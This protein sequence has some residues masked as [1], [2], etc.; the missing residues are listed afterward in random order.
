MI[1]LG[2]IPLSSLIYFNWKIYKGIK[3]PPT[4]L[5]QD[6]D[7]KRRREQDYDLAKVLIGIVVTFISCHTFRVVI[8]FH[9]IMVH[10]EAFECAKAGL[11]VFSMWSILI[12]YLSD[13]M[14]GLNS[15]V[16]MIIYCCLNSTF[17]K[18]FFPCKNQN[19]NRMP[20]TAFT[21][22]IDISEDNIEMQ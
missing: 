4:L 15:S 8:E 7:R 19:L 6:D 17:R 16:N 21:R 20:S 18:S 1:I 22:T 11:R 5:Q 2:I 9:N 10:G 12:D 13:F 14:L 3:F